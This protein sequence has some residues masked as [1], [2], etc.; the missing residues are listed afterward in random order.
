MYVLHF[1]ENENSIIFIL[2]N[3]YYLL[4]NKN[5]TQL[6]ILRKLTIAID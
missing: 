3:I 2:I 1:N 4:M 6:Y 5:F